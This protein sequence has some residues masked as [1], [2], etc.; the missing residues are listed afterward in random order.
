MS[1]SFD[2]S[3][4]VS[5]SEEGNCIVWDVASRQSLRKYE[6]HK[7][8]VTFVSVMLR[9]PELVTGSASAHDVIPM[10]WKKFSRTVATEDDEQHS[11]SLQL[12]TDTGM[13]RFSQ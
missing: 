10:P 11:E 6:S 13:V 7:G 8:P 4:L 9:P 3:L 2:G 1:L 12:I 5:A